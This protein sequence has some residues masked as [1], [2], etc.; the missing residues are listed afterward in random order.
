MQTR[1]EI[2]LVAL[3]IYSVAKGH[4]VI[5]L[6]HVTNPLPLSELSSHTNSPTIYEFLSSITKT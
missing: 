3:K 2:N 5:C 6:F 1:K 4:L